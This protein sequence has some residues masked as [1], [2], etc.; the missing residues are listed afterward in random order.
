MKRN[1]T[2]SSSAVF[3]PSVQHGAVPAA[4]DL[5]N[6][7]CSGPHVM[8]TSPR[9]T[10]RRYGLLQVAIHLQFS[11]HVTLG[12][13]RH[14]VIVSVITLSYNIETGHS[15]MRWKGDDDAV[16]LDLVPAPEGPWIILCDHDKMLRH[17]FRPT[18]PCIVS[19]LKPKLWAPNPW[20][21]PTLGRVL[22]YKHSRHRC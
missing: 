18:W 19:G 6:G 9:W 15:W 4:N 22:H 8:R 3:F 17:L 5:L 2:N 1:K 14:V 16:L 21:S 11:C 13:S 10:H 12:F 20:L 7:C